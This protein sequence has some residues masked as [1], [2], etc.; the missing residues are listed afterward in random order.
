MY[1]FSD[2]ELRDLIEGLPKVIYAKEHPP[3]RV[4]LLGVRKRLKNQGWK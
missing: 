4:K 1:E 2:R 3:I